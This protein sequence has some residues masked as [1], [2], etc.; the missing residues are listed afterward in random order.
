MT[1]SECL[2]ELQRMAPGKVALVKV[3]TMVFVNGDYRTRWSVYVEGHSYAS[4]H[5]TPEAA[6][7]EMS[8]KLGISVTETTD[9]EHVDA[10]TVPS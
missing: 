5:A 6:L 10:H 7:G 3:E 2:A 1:Y 4:E 9:I 8:E